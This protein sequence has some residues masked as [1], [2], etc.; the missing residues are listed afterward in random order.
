[1]VQRDGQIKRKAQELNKITIFLEEHKQK[2][3]NKK[4]VFHKTQLKNKLLKI[5]DKKL[6]QEELEEFL[7]SAKNSKLL[8]IITQKL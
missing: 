1:M 2:S 8:M 6:L 3:L 7:E 4:L 5:L